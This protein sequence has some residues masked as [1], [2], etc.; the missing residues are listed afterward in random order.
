M[1]FAYA[2]G[3]AVVV[4]GPRI[5]VFCYLDDVERAETVEDCLDV[6]GTL[7]R[8]VSNALSAYQEVKS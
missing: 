2:S 3:K 8:G 7:E 5:N 6:I 1:G 4:Y